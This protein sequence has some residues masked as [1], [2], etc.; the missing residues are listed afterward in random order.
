M[1]DN[2]HHSQKGWFIIAVLTTGIALAAFDLLTGG[3]RTGSFA[4]LLLLAAA[5]LLFYRLQVTIDDNALTIRFGIGIIKKQLSLDDVE[6]VRIVKNPWYWGWGIRWIGKR[7][8]LY[9]VSGFDA[10]ELKMKSDRTYRIGTDRPE[11]LEA[12]VGR[13]LEDTFEDG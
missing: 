12:A 4:G 3:F 1:T 11:A 5:L 9:N 2:Y 10:V 8:W 7:F 6:S 13:A